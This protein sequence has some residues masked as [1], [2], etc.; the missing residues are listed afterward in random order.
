MNES[1]S[2][3]PPARAKSAPLPPLA[4]SWRRVLGG[5]VPFPAAL[6]AAAALFLLLATLGALTDWWWCDE[7]LSWDMIQRTPAKIIAYTAGDL[8]PPLYFLALSLWHLL[9]HQ[10]EAMKYFSMA[11]GLF[12][13]LAAAWTGRLLAGRRTGVL[14]ALLWATFPLFLHYSQDARMYPLGLALETLALAGWALAARRPGRGWAIF[15]LGLTACLYTHNFCLLFAAALVSGETARCLLARRHPQSHRL[16]GGAGLAW[17][18]SSALTIGVLYAPWL[19]VPFRQ[20]HSWGNAQFFQAPTWTEAALKFIF[21]PY[22]L[23]LVPSVRPLAW[24]AGILLL[25]VLPVLTLR[26]LTPQPDDNVPNA[27]HPRPM[28]MFLWVGLVPFLFIIL[29]SKYVNPIVAIRHSVLFIPFLLIP[30]ANWLAARSARP[31]PRLACLALIAGTGALSLA[32]LRHSRDADL[33]LYRDALIER[34]PL[35][36]PIYFYPPILPNTRLL[37]D[38]LPLDTMED[39]QQVPRDITQCTLVVYAGADSTREEIIRQAKRT[40]S[41]AVAV[42]KIFGSYELSAYSLKGLPPGALADLLRIGPG[43]GMGTVEQQAGRW[44]PAPVWSSADLLPRMQPG[45]ELISLSQ[46]NPAWRGLRLSA[47]HVSLDL[48]WP[49]KRTSGHFGALLLGGHC[50]TDAPSETVR[51]RLNSGM[52]YASELG[53]GGFLLG[54]LLP[55]PNDAARLEIDLPPAVAARRFAPNGD[56]PRG[57]YLTWAGR[58]D[59]KPEDFRRPKFDGAY[60]DVGS[61]GD[62]LYLRSGFHEA[63]GMPPTEARWTREHFEM[64]VPVWPGTD[65][66]EIVMI[67]RLPEAIR[68]RRIAVTVEGGKGILKAQGNI[69]SAKYGE[70]VLR[71]PEALRPGIYRLRF[72]VGTW[73]PKAAGMGGDARQ[74]GFFLDGVGLRAVRGGQKTPSD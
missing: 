7:A 16:G 37:W 51:S 42:R 46:I 74:L 41:R 60:F 26:D 10:P 62:E 23:F 43:F 27:G 38:P 24:L 56:T 31:G 21:Y 72:T 30:T 59:L 28:A 53:R 49:G 19:I 71:L 55:T 20:L 61:V 45:G 58:L 12:A 70:H 73:S 18:I 40:A 54:R 48:S 47:P 68:N 64:E 32:G 39:N 52:E 29:Y 8:H 22:A 34:A 36:A 63:E 5:E 6:A 44:R 57:V 25:I 9:F 4:G 66:R 3:G 1:Q 13:L 67:G 65:Y 2:A 14:V 69:E 35:N 50:I 11:A 17:I 15:T 33:A